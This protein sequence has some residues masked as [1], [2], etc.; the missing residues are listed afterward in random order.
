MA[1]WL[2]NLREFCR[3]WLAILSSYKL[4]AVFLPE[5]YLCMIGKLD[6][7]FV[8]FTGLLIISVRAF[9]AALRLWPGS[10]PSE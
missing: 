9:E 8:F 7:V 5:C 6:G 3:R 2:C 10:K 1:E 4:L